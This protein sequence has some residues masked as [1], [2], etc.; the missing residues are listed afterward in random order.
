MSAYFTVNDPDDPLAQLETKTRRAQY[1][2]WSA[3]LP[4]DDADAMIV[5]KRLAASAGVTQDRALNVLLALRRL[6]DLPLLSELQGELFHLDFTRLIAIDRALNKADMKDE[7]TA[8][9]LD[10]HITAF[11][12]PK[13]P[14]QHLPSARQIKTFIDD[15]ITGMDSSVASDDEMPP[16]PVDEYGYS[17][18]S[19]RASM[20]HATLPPEI[21]ALVDAHI[22]AAAEEHGISLTE[23]FTQLC[24]GQIKPV[25]RVTVNVYSGKEHTGRGFVPGYGWM[26]IDEL[27]EITH[28]R[29][30]DLAE[31]RE[32]DTYSPSADIVAFV[33][34][35]HSTCCFP[36]CNRPAVDCQLDHRVNFADGGPTAAKNLF[37]LCQT[38]HNVKT[39]KRAFYVNDPIA[40][41]I[42]WLFSDGRWEVASADGPLAPDKAHWLRTMGQVAEARAE[43][44]RLVAQ[45]VKAASTGAR[46][47]GLS[48]DEEAERP[49]EV[50]PV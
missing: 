4:G 27:G 47:D 26:E 36:G 41:D 5:T 45:Q 49:M 7:A 16:E 37:P 25:A 12:S 14:R 13:R 38:H 29:D 20:V 8:S 39:D 35:R 19:K 2:A 44:C 18:V 11:L 30:M 22:R 43:N 50:V 32:V 15:L 28:R 9:Y 21:A 1:L 34:G 31:E 33:C 46:N 3:F 24:T 17:V 48:F 6:V 10:V 42:Y 40:G 23:A